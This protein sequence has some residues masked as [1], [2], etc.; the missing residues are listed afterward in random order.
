MLVDNCIWGKKLM[1][2]YTVL[3]VWDKDVKSLLLKR[4]FILFGHIRKTIRDIYLFIF[5]LYSGFIPE[6]SVALPMLS[7]NY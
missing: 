7:A 5:S 1:W 6:P 3:F 4:E 2:P